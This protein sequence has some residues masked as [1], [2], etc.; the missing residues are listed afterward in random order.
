MSL[1]ALPLLILALGSLGASAVLSRSL[2][3]QHAAIVGT[4]APT[5]PPPEVAVPSV[6]L[7]AFRGLVV[8]YLWLRACRLEEAGNFYEAKDLA[9]WISALEPRLEQVWSFQAHDL[10]YNLCAA[11]DDAEGRWKWIQEGIALLRDKGLKTNPRSPELYFMLS[12]IYSDKIGGPFDD[13]H[14]VLKRMLAI[15]L[16]RAFGPLGEDPDLHGLAQAGS[17]LDPEAALLLARLKEA[18]LDLTATTGAI[19]EALRNSAAARA[20]AKEASPEVLERVKCFFRARCARELGL[21]P[22][23]CLEIEERYGPLDWRGC[24][25]VSLY[26]AVQGLHAAEKLGPARSVKAERKLGRLAI[27]SLKH[28]VRRGRLILEPGGEIF[29]A[30][31]PRLVGRVVALYDQEI[32]RARAAVESGER[33]APDEEPDDDEEH[34]RP[35]EDFSAFAYLKTMDEARS[36]FLVEGISVLARYGREAEA[37]K[38]YSVLARDHKD[39]AGT[40]YEDL[41]NQILTFEVLGEGSNQVQTYQILLG[42]WTRAWLALA[43]GDDQEALGRIALADRVHREWRKKVE[44]LLRQGDLKALQRLGTVDLVKIKNQALEDA[45]ARLGPAL[46]RRLEERAQTYMKPDEEKK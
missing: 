43:R 30:P 38:L 14:L 37:R 23:S 34:E 35:K 26:W 8:D 12:R 36:E 20:L 3:E 1:R 39:L 7:G 40:S 28:A 32:A 25:A 9:E 45:R 24:D 31:E 2:D 17:E 19:D 11:A 13:Y 15:Q 46:R 10:A 4:V 16:V 6:L 42:N 41:V 44:E 33:L 18:G 29:L 5:A 27:G 21:D 22:A